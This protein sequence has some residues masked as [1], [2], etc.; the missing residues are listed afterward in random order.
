MYNIELT[1]E[2]KVAWKTNVHRPD[3]QNWY[4]EKHLSYDMA[5]DK[6]SKVNIL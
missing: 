6:T 5:V 2:W 4:S 1:S 3:R